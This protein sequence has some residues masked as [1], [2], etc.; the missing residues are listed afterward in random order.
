MACQQE[1]QEEQVKLKQSFRLSIKATHLRK[2]VK[3][4]F[5]GDLRGGGRKT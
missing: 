5:E 2:I 4:I 3:V 1:E